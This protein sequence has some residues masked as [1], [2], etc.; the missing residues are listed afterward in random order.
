MSLLGRLSFRIRSWL[1]AVLNRVEDPGQALDY[2]YEQLR[3]ELQDVNRGIAT[4]TTQKKRL[5]MHRE[6]LRA[7]VE[8]AGRFEFLEGGRAGLHL[9]GALGGA[10]LLINQQTL[11]IGI[12]ALGQRRP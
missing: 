11:D 1:N 2:S 12:P 6:R 4:I 3:D 8:C 7:A 5:E 10:L 9:L